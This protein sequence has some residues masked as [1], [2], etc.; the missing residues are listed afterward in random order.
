MI[1][2]SLFKPCPWLKSPHAQ[3][4]WASKLRWL[5]RLKAS[6]ERVTLPDG[7]FL[8][9]AWSQKESP[10][11][12]CLFHGLGGSTDSPY[13]RGM[14]FALEKA[15][16]RPVFV[17]FRGASKEPN[18][19]VYA[20]H[21]GHTEDIK[22]LVRRFRATQKHQTVS[23]IGFSLGANALLKYLGEEGKES[24]LDFSI[25]VSPPLVLDVA[26]NQMNQGFAKLYQYVLLR[27]IKEQ[28]KTKKNAYPD[29]DIYNDIESLSS[30][31]EL[32]DM[33]TGPVNGFKDAADYYR[34]CS[35]RQ[36]LKDIRAPTHVIHSKDDPF[37][38][39]AVIPDEE[40]LSTHVSFELSNH[41][42]HV[43]FVSG[44]N[45]LKLN[46]WLEPRCIELLQHV[47]TARRRHS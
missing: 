10:H 6:Q 25:A 37:F 26:A 39:P 27:K 18:T 35:A 33:V 5:P 44:R 30:F 19:K 1:H 11:L 8:E 46:Y 47:L 7:D 41:G 43:A 40:E 34:Q 38:T 23:S 36:Y 45:P 2:E 12:V 22:F 3:T 16:F 20:Y 15:G 42:G 4:I 14:F 21:S 32:D 28:L 29:L 31:W 13:A 24:L 9:L 17:T